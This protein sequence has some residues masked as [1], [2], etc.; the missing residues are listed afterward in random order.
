MLALVL[1]V[2]GGLGGFALYLNHVVDS[3]VRRGGLLPDDQGRPEPGAGSSRNILLLG[4]DSLTDQLRDGAR[5]DVI[6]LV[7]VADDRSS[8]QVV[9]FPRDLY[10]DI[11]GHGKNK[12]NAAYA[13]GGAPLLVKT[14]EQL[15]GVRIDHVAVTG[16]AGFKEL[17]DTVGGV[18]VRVEQAS[19]SGGVRFTPGVMH[20]DGETALAFVRERKQLREGDLDR[21]R[22][23]QAWMK[24]LLEKSA[25]T[26]TLSNPARLAAMIGDTTRNLVVDES[27]TTGRIRELAWSLRGVRGSDVSFITAPITGFDTVKGAGSVDVVDQAGIRRLGQALREDDTAALAALSRTPG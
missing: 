13:Y 2:V 17:T 3:N 25:S 26:G 19:T 9:H 7:H 14:L 11:P 16:F 22:R 21:G 1:L 12:I 15:L 6:Q 4:S 27:F 20:M 24:A 5:A 23:Q 8:M 18:D 10:V